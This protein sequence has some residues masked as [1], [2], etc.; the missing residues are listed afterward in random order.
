VV[1]A[2]YWRYRGAV[3]AILGGKV[4]AQDGLHLAGQ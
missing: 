3:L 1:I 2:C 4:D